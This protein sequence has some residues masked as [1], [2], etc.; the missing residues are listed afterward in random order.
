MGTSRTRTPTFT[1]LANSLTNNTA[2]KFHSHRNPTP[3]SD[4][5]DSEVA[6]PDWFQLMRHD[7]VSVVVTTENLRREK[8]TGREFSFAVL[9]TMDWL[10]S[11]TSITCIYGIWCSIRELSPTFRGLTNLM[12]QRS[13]RS[14]WLV[15]LMLGFKILQS[16]PKLLGRS[17]LRPPAPSPQ[18]NV[19]I[20]RYRFGEATHLSTGGGGGIISS[21]YMI[22]SVW[23]WSTEFV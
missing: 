17:A 10:L 6:A 2:I 22:S 3:P 1:R 23:E 4:G 5:M 12:P 19:E 20:S 7:Y 13:E 16:W 18:F 21:S 8:H 11:A 15:F 9:G 14:C